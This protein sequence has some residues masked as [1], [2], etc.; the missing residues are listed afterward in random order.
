MNA[1]RGA[2]DAGQPLLSLSGI[3]KCFNG[4]ESLQAVDLELYPGEIL[5]L[6]GDNGAGKS[7]LIK[8]LSGVYKPDKGQLVVRG[9]EVDFAD[10]TV[11]KARLAG[12]ETV[13]Q[14]GSFGEKQPLWRNVFIGRSLVNRLGFINVK[15]QKRIT[16]EILKKHVGLGGPGLS[17]NA[18]V[19]TLS[20]GERQGLAIGRAMY[21]NSDIVVLDEPTTALSINEVE[22]VLDFIRSIAGS[23]RGCIFISHNMNHIARLASRVVVLDKGKTV[24]NFAIGDLSVTDV[25]RRVLSGIA[26]AEEI[27]T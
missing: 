7:T 16:L 23:S 27:M 17:C 20:G 3:S 25:N 22:K 6:V 24:D 2:G 12:I 11:H 14:D 8:I 4:I 10:Y 5:G 1:S 19:S 13:F 18:K 26:V 15:K 21:F 9:R